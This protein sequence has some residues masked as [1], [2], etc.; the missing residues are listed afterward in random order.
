MS[1]KDAMAA[2]KSRTT[3][4][5]NEAMREVKKEPMKRLNVNIAESKLKQFKGK[6]ASEG[7]EMSTL[8]HQWIDEYMSI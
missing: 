2:K 6:A 3:P 1:L 5:K 8:I 4:K 7:V